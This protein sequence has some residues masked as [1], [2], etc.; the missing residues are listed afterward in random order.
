VQIAVEPQQDADQGRRAEPNRDVEDV[1]NGTILAPQMALY[2][3]PGSSFPLAVSAAEWPVLS[4]AQA[5]IQNNS[6]LSKDLPPPC[7]GWRFRRM[8][9]T[10]SYARGSFSCGFDAA[11]L[12]RP[13]PWT[14]A[15]SLEDYSITSSARASNGRGE[16]KAKRF[17]GLE[18]YNQLNFHRLLDG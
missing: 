11:R 3:L 17:G 8:P 12:L 16:G 15:R 2:R 9:V 18:I 14:C 10:H 4:L 1:H 7:G 5:S 13:S 6:G